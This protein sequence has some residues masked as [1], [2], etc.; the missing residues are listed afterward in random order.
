MSG[1]DGNPNAL[2]SAK[3]VNDQ[4]PIDS[5]I[6]TDQAR[7]GAPRP[8]HIRPVYLGLVALGG[9]V[10]TAI[11]EL[12]TLG[13]PPVDDVSV[14]IIAINVLGAFILGLLLEALAAAGPDHG[15]RR[16]VRLLFG[17]GVLGGFTTY[18]TLAT[19]TALL[20]THGRT[21][22][23]IVYTIATLLLGAAATFAGIAQAT[24]L[25]HRRRNATVAEARR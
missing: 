18:S 2:E 7:G 14:V 12:L 9:M 5:D 8:V 17:T 4:L 15:R 19:D 24:A 6:E 21:E 11:R 3:T 16:A 13:V 10:G 1:A 20:F 23:A 22:T 25:R